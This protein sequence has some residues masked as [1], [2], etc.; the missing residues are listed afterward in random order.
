M[1]TDAVITA[2]CGDCGVGMTAEVRGSK[3]V[4][5][6]GF[7]HFAVPARRWWDNIGFA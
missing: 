5:D 2:P 6:E 3:L 1:G 7:I 4:R